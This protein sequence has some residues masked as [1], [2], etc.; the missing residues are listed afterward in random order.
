MKCRISLFLET[1]LSCLQDRLIGTLCLKYLA[2]SCCRA[3]GV[4]VSFRNREKFRLLQ[5]FEPRD[6]A[7]NRSI[8]TNLKIKQVVSNFRGLKQL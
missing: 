6:A 2:A 8:E 3:Y 5:S 7:E 1:P 4:P